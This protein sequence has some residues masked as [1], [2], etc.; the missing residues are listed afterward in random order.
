MSDNVLVDAVRAELE[1]DP[2][3]NARH[4]GV[5]A[6]DGAVVLTG[7]VP[8]DREKVAAVR[9]AERVDGVG[10][11]ADELEVQRLLPGEFTDAEIAEEIAHRRARNPEIPVTVEA[12]VRDGHVTLRGEVESQQQRAV[13][14]H[15]VRNLL[16]VRSVANEV[17]VRP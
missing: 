4:V 2:E 9:A 15:M 13:T 1:R 14:E 6:V 12:E 8:L 3:V 5:S 11:V 10:A 7:Y 17:V 16:G